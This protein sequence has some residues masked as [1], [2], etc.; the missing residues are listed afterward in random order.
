[1]CEIEHWRK[2]RTQTLK[3]TNKI[4]KTKVKSNIK[5]NKMMNDANAYTQ[6]TDRHT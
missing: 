2:K 4:D 5:T 1:M 3:L 6:H